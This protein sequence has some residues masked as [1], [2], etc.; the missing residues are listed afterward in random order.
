MGITVTPA[1]GSV[2]A[3]VEGIELRAVDDQASRACRCL[4]RPRRAV[5]PRSASQPRRADRGGT[6]SSASPSCSTSH[7]PS[8]T[9]S[10]SCIGSS[11]KRAGASV[12]CPPG[13]PM[14][15]GSN[16]H[17]AARCSRR[18]SSPPSAATPC[19][20]V[21]TT[22]SRTCRSPCT[23]GRRTHRQPPRGRAAH[24]I[25]PTGSVSR[26]LMTRWCTPW[27]RC[28]LEVVRSASSSTGSSPNTST[29]SSERESDV[30][31]PAAV[32]PVQRS[33]DPVPVPLGA[34]RHRSLGQPRGPALC[35]VRLR[36]GRQMDRV[37]LAGDPT[38]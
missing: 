10:R 5:L 28:T 23:A 36:R 4:A 38:H 18:S 9:I 35:G 6:R 15:P 21:P 33:R 7:R 24:A 20:P 30:L 31:L 12:A 14:P 13:T 2:G 17:H 19:S 37:V 11:W 16:A 27:S 34:R 25:L 32:R 29:S 1:S 26:S 3:Y 8:A 22:P